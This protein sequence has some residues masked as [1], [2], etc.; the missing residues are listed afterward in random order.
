MTSYNFITKLLFACNFLF[1]L[2]FKIPLAIFSR[3]F[4][5]I[6]RQSEQHGKFTFLK[7]KNIEKSRLVRRDF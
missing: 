1:C 3:S 5:F 2:P 6:H 4:Y 7:Q